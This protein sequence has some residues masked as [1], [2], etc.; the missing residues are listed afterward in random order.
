MPR[1]HTIPPSRLIYKKGFCET[2][3]KFARYINF[4]AN[5]M[6]VLVFVAIISSLMIISLAQ[7]GNQ[8]AVLPAGGPPVI[9]RCCLYGWYDCCGYLFGYRYGQLPPQYPKYPPLP[10][11][12]NYI[13]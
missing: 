4:G 6:K 3:Y 10:L 2:S 7:E 9:S 5:I 12:S 11:S 13:Y 1:I 8:P